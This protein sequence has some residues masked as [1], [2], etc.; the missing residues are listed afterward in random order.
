MRKLCFIKFLKNM[1][2]Q[3]YTYQL[4]HHFMSHYCWLCV[5][6]ISEF[7]LKKK[8]WKKKLRISCNL[9]TCPSLV[10]NL[11]FSN[12]QSP[13]KKVQFL[14][15][16]FTFTHKKKKRK[17]PQFWPLIYSVTLFIICNLF[18]SLFFIRFHQSKP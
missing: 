6:P 7:R 8:F 9:I 12:S 13:N 3:V 2:T 5:S 4:I 16:R 11:K 1:T 14:E 15:N 18:K 10:K 17:W